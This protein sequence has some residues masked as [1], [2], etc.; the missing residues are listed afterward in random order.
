MP[1][2]H[3]SKRRAVNGPMHATLQCST[4]R[5]PRSPI[6]SAG[7]CLP[8]KGRP[9]L[10]IAEAL[11]PLRC[12]ILLRTSGYNTHDV[13]LPALRINT[14]NLISYNATN[15]RVNQTSPMVDERMRVQR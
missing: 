15:C 13:V 2:H 4:V 6:R 3:P 12:R 14:T 1:S 7:D 5:M 10:R 9:L 11:S 8:V